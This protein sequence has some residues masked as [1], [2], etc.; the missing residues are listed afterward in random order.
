MRSIRTIT[1]SLLAAALLLLGLSGCSPRTEDPDET[2]APSAGTTV[3]SS[4]SAAD[5][6]AEGR[7][8]DV[9]RTCFFDYTVN[10]A[11][12]CANYAGYTPAANNQLLV[13]S[14]TITNTGRYSIEMYDS[15]FQAQWGSAGDEDFALPI[16]ENT[17]PVSESQLPAVYELGVNETR[18]GLLVFEVPQ[19]NRDFSISY[20]EV[21]DN[22]TE[23]DVF[24][25]Y[26][27]AASE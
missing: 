20:L 5:G 4:V 22:D 3:D 14:V 27:T 8:G 15:D 11:Y 21:F 10:E 6:F 1:A 25:V 13:A 9:M 17:D 23:G 24:F 7:L 18:T 12:T 16:T 26:F 2:A 19:G